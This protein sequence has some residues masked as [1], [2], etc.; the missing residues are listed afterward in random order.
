VARPLGF[1]GI[2]AI[3][4]GASGCLDLSI[5]HFCS[6]AIAPAVDGVVVTPLFSIA[7]V[8]IVNL[9]AFT[10]RFLGMAILAI[11]FDF[12]SPAVTMHCTGLGSYRY[13]QRPG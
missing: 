6:V 8:A 13:S 4:D 5:F 11:L 2:V 9:S 7:G 1:A 12:S 3:G 10:G